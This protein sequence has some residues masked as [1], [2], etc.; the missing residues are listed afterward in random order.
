MAAPIAA[1][2][3]Y[4]SRNAALRLTAAGHHSWTSSRPERWVGCPTTVIHQGWRPTR[5]GRSRCSPQWP[6]GSGTSRSL[7]AGLYRASA[8]K[9]TSVRLPHC[10]AN[11]GKPM[12]ILANEMMYVCARV[13]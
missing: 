6:F 13:N 7:P 11:A 1:G 5:S 9:P 12:A 3:P 8:I 2:L 10:R 4:A